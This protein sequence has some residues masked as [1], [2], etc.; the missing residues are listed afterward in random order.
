MSSDFFF[1]ARKETLKST[2][3]QLILK[4]DQVKSI[5]VLERF[6]RALIDKRR[7]FCACENEIMYSISLSFNYLI[8]HNLF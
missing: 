1:A 2:C 4:F 8:L 5:S 7:G 6:Q 3:Y